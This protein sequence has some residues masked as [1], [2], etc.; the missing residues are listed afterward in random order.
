MTPLQ[1]GPVRRWLGRLRRDGFSELPERAVEPFDRARGSANEPDEQAHLLAF[2]HQ[3]AVRFI[4]LSLALAVERPFPDPQRAHEPSHAE[5]HEQLDDVAD[6]GL[7]LELKCVLS[8]RNDRHIGPWRGVVGWPVADKRRD[9]NHRTI[10]FARQD[11]AIADSQPGQ[12]AGQL[13]RC[14]FALW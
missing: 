3:S 14:G 4:E 6:H 1:R 11:E 12:R 7:L 8:S 2:S 5:L 13:Q 9:T 10:A